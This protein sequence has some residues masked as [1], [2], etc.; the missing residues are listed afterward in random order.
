M[1]QLRVN[2]CGESSQESRMRENR[3]SGSMRGE[4]ASG[5]GMG[6]LR[7]PRG[8]PETD[9]VKRISPRND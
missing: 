2:A 1:R 8:N 5:Y 9:L 7:H 3:T 6:L 4:G